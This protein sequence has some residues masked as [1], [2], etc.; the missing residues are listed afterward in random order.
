[1]FAETSSFL[2]CSLYLPVHMV[3]ELE[4]YLV[5]QLLDFKLLINSTETADTVKS[6]VSLRVTECL[7]IFMFIGADMHWRG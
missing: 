3:T 4:K 6:N 1:M 7:F 5:V 2:P